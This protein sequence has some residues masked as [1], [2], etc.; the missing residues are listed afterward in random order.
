M[1]EAGAALGKLLF[2]ETDL[3]GD[4]KQ[5][6]ATCHVPDSGFTKP[7]IRLKR[8]IP[9]LWNL[10]WSPSFFWDGS[11]ENL[12]SM[13]FLPLTDSLEMHGQ[14]FAAARNLQKKP[15][16]RQAFAR[17]FGKDTVYSAL[18]SRALAQYVRT[19]VLPMPD[20][21][22]FSPQEKEGFLIFQKACAHCHAGKFGTDFRLRKSVL[23]A[24]GPD[25]GRFH[26]SRL[27]KDTFVFKTPGLAQISKTA[28][29]MHN[30]A[31]PDLDSLLR[32]YAL[33]LPGNEWKSKATLAQLKAYLLKL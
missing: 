32:G 12:E 6:C 23:A 28:P 5:S 15:E 25:F 11:Q 24:S 18:I 30:N 2:F 10:A 33:V 26:V 14:L 8:A 17:A 31:I 16:W 1:T 22:G 3:S 4:G 13:I 29:Y 9:T 21:F 7:D 19:L 27:P 20:T